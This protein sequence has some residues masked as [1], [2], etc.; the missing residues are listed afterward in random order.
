M[1][2]SESRQLAASRLA[3]VDFDSYFKEAH[4]E[5]R[6]LTLGEAVQLLRINGKL[7]DPKTGDVD[8]NIKNYVNAD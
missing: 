1:A 2:V 6:E 3:Y 5:G 4:D 8:G 7:V